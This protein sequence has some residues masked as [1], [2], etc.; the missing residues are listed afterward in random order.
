MRHRQHST[1]VYISIDS[2]RQIR[3]LE[4]P[5]LCQI[6]RTSKL[7]VQ[8]RREVLHGSVLGCLASGGLKDD[9]PDPGGSSRVRRSRDLMG[10]ALRR[11]GGN[12]GKGGAG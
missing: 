1:H 4:E 10:D 9:S 7:P 3:A 8:G 11:P 6:P 5:A 2:W 12:P